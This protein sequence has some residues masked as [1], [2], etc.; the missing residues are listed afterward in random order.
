MT[1]S[2]HATIDHRLIADRLL[3]RRD[4]LRDIPDAMHAAC[5]LARGMIQEQESFD[6][7]DGRTP[8][9]TTRALD[10]LLA[11]ISFTAAHLTQQIEDII[12]EHDFDLPTMQ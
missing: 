9:N 8:Y 3:V 10:G 2:N 6:M 5:E 1:T 11:M 7:E 12:G 4:D